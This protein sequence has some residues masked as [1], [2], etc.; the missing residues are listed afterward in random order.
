MAQVL[1][2]PDIKSSK[3]KASEAF[4]MEATDGDCPGWKESLVEVAE[5]LRRKKEEEKLTPADHAAEIVR[6]QLKS[7]SDEYQQAKIISGI[8]S[9]INEQKMKIK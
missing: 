1:Q 8:I 2:K 7:I 6:A 5:M 9:Y 3:R 4:G